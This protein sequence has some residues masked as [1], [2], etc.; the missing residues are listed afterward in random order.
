[1]SVRRR[2]VSTDALVP[3]FAE[4]YES[5]ISDL[6]SGGFDPWVFETL[7]TKTRAAWLRRKG[8]S[9]SGVRSLHLLGCAADTIC[10]EHRWSCTRHGCRFFDALGDLAKAR[11]L[12][13]GGDMFPRNPV[14]GRRFVDKPHVQAVS[15]WRQ[16]RLRAAE[17]PAEYVARVLGG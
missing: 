2:I 17:D 10:R 12:H 16:K 6:R 8:S 11:G 15:Y 7:R 13:W 1:M 5:V 3:A 4:R 9:K 14:T